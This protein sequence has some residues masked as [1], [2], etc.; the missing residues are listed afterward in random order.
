MTEE[1]IHSFKIFPGK[2]IPLMTGNRNAKY[3]PL[4]ARLNKKDAPI[5]TKI[6]ERLV[7]HLSRIETRESL[8]PV[9]KVRYGRTCM[10]APCEVRAS[11]PGA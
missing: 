8:R 5:V 3:V 2:A 4:R 6:A 11:K 9:A 10:V 1:N 7:N